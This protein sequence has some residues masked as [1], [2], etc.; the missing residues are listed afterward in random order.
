MQSET[1]WSKCPVERNHFGGFGEG[2]G[3]FNQ[4]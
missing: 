1:E 3:F 2:F 4:V